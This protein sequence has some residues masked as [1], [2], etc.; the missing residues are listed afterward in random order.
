MWHLFL[1][2]SWLLRNP[3]MLASNSEASKLNKQKLFFFCTWCT[4]SGYWAQGGQTDL[5]FLDKQM[6]VDHF[7]SQLTSLPLLDV[8]SDGL[9]IIPTSRL[10]SLAVF[11]DGLLVLIFNIL[12]TIYLTLIFL[13][14]LLFGVCRDFQAFKLIFSTTLLSVIFFKMLFSAPVSFLSLPGTAVYS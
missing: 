14:S 12:A 13:R 8:T 4:S 9:E 1:K 7:L 2:T 6:T 11:S 10:F 5:V 3:M